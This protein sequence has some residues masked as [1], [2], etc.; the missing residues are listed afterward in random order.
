MGEKEGGRDGQW[1]LFLLVLQA[2]REVSAEIQRD[3]QRVGHLK[4]ENTEVGIKS[5]ILHVV[6]PLFSTVCVCASGAPP[7]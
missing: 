4:Q 3:S 7:C 2:V 5:A 1:L 6:F